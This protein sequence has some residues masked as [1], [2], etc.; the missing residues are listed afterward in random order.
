MKSKNELPT[1]KTLWIGE[2]TRLEITCLNSFLKHG[3]KVELYSYAKIQNLPKEVIEKDANEIIPE[4]KIFKYGKINKE[5]KGSVAG[6]ANHFRYKLLYLSENTFWVDTD[7]ICIKPLQID[8]DLIFGWENS[9]YIN[10]AIIGTMRKGN[11]LFSNLIEY[12][13]RPF[14]L[15]KWDDYKTILKKLYG[16]FLKGGSTDYIPWGLTGPKA[17]TGYV[18]SLKL[19]EYALKKKCFYPIE[20][21]DWK[22]I[23]YTDKSK[24]EL[25]DSFFLH[26]WNEQLRREK[27]NKNQVF[28]T[29]SIYEFYAKNDS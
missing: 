14:Q 25:K 4:T 2:L 21:N 27:I 10:N 7:V 13:E 15:K 26:L 22:K 12:C 8:K 18:N 1:I 9:K 5:G 19:T 3:H 6:F 17:L 20:S 24:I 29:K 11:P 16:Y 28:N 23:F